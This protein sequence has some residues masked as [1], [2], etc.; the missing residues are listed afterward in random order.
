ML[1]KMCLCR[2]VRAAPALQDQAGCWRALE[3]SS[4]TQVF[5]KSCKIYGRHRPPPHRDSSSAVR[6]MREKKHK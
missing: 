4:P 2:F 5:A 3:V 1:P 6:V